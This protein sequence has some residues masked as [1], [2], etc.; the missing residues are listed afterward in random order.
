MR[1]A[2]K[3]RKTKANGEA[4]PAALLLS[5]G[6]GAVELGVE[7]DPADEAV[8]DAV[9]VTVVLCTLGLAEEVRVGVLV[10]LTELLVDSVVVVLVN[11]GTL[12]SGAD[13]AAEEAAEEAG[14]EDA[15]EDSGLL[16]AAEEAP[17]AVAEAVAAEEAPVTEPEPP[18]SWN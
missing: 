3:A 7:E 11:G 8:E 4:R 12:D 15:A 10:V 13:E 17:E 9:E 5:G 1:R 2:A 6:G 14:A 18:V 16:E